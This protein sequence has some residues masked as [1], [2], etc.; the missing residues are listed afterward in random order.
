MPIRGV[1]S[2]IA[3][4]VAATCLTVFSLS[5][6]A[7]AAETLTI[8]DTSLTPHEGTLQALSGDST[9]VF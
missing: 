5:V 9:P 2:T 3:C 8:G 7:A 1:T 6:T 4:A